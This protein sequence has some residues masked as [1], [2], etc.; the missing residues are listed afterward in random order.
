[1]L[2]LISQKMAKY[3]YVCQVCEVTEE[4]DLPFDHEIPK[5]K[6]CDLH[7]LKTYQAPGIIFKGTGF[8]KT[9]NRQ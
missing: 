5:C 9:D 2:G 4:L 1:L 6:K 3:D 8:Y 7:M